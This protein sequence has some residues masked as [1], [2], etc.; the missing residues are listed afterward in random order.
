MKLKKQKQKQNYKILQAPEWCEMLKENQT[1][2]SQECRERLSAP[3]G[4]GNTA[5][6]FLRN[7]HIGIYVY[8]VLP[9]ELQSANFSV[10]KSHTINLLS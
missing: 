1:L 8:F 7:S 6:N 10:L 5:G 3:V 2:L 4:V 9:V